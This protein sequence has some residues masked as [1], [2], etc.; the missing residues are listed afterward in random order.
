MKKTTIIIASLIIGLTQFSCN[1]EFLNKT[2]PTRIGVNTFYQ[3]QS[4]IDRALNGIYGQLQDIINDEWLYSELTS[5]NTTVDFNPDDR[6][7]ASNREQFEYWVLNPGTPNIRTMYNKYYNSLFNINYTLSK[8]P[9]ISDPSVKAVEGQLKFLRAYY[10]FNLTRYF[11]DVILITEALDD[12]TKAWEYVRES[13]SNVYAQIEN[14]AKDAVALLPVNYDATSKGKIT[15]GAALTLLG[16]L[17]LTKKQYTD[18]VNTLSEVLPLGY[19]LLTSYADVFDPNNKNS[20]ESIFEVQYQGG[21]D[22]GEWSGFIYTFAPRLSKDAITGWPQ[23]NPGGWG[24]PTKD[25]IE[26]YE[27]GDL[28]KAA[29]IGLDFHSPI[30]GDV[31]PYIKKYAHPHAIYGRT[32]DNWFVFRY[33]N[34]LLMLAE[35][36]NEQSGPSDAYQYLN[37]VRTRAG[38]SPLSGLDKETLRTAIDHERRVEFAFENDRWFF[39]KRT[40]TPEELASFLNAYAA[41]EKSDP[42]VTRQGI[43]YSGGDYVFNAN[44]SLFPVPAEEIR[45]NDK[46]TQNDGY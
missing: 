42:T 30:T 28:R 46:L 22:L 27:D 44:E 12:P 31:V 34:V 18:A 17:Y 29:S 20:V 1:K 13:Q 37:R 9:D 11:G 41:R 3:D 2:D 33:S 26:S 8:L 14:D 21:N 24:I 5:D 35:A 23:S 15:K 38:L 32:D 16:T 45:I 4:Q 7:Q 10:Y 40:K 36:I 25:L 19:D 6:G 43:P 39:L